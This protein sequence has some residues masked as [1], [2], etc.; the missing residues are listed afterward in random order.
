MSECNNNHF[1]WSRPAMTPELIRDICIPDKQTEQTLVS[2]SVKW[3]AD[4][5]ID[6]SDKTPQGLG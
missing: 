6:V 3:W 1:D 2:E 5:G 4:H